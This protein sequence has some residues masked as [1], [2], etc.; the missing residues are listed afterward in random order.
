MAHTS[1]QV[2]SVNSVHFRSDLETRSTIA[3]SSRANTESWTAHPDRSGRPDYTGLLCAGRNRNHST[4]STLQ[5]GSSAQILSQPTGGRAVSTLV[6]SGNDWNS[7]SMTRADGNSP[8]ALIHQGASNATAAAESIRLPNERD[9]SAL[10]RTEENSLLVP[11]SYLGDPSLHENLSAPIPPDQST[12]LWIRGM[13]PS[14]V[15]SDILALIRNTGKVYSIFVNPP[16]SG[17][18]G[19]AAKICFFTRAAA[20]KFFNDTRGGFLIKGHR[21]VVLWNRILLPEHNTNKWKKACRVVIVQGPRDLVNLRRIYEILDQN[22]R[23][24]DLERATEKAHEF[25]H[26]H[27]E[28]ELHFGSFRAQGES[29][30]IVLKRNWQAKGV[31]VLYGTDPCE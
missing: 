6:Y 25:R 31:R 20:E 21:A 16:S 1:P 10:V 27:A 18:A 17:H 26:G 23:K 5:D 13:A 12:S 29:A 22:I 14:V 15:F 30:W 7:T 9:T 4:P 19:S 24:Y 2:P 8:K 3:S 28:V 11:I